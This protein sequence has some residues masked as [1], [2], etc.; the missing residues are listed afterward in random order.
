MHSISRI[1]EIPPRDRL[2]PVAELLVAGALI[3]G[4]NILDVVPTSETPWLVALGWLSLRLRGCSWR[5]LG[6]PRP[7]RWLATAGT[8]QAPAVALQLISELVIEPLTGRADLSEFHSLAGILP[9]SLGMLAVVWTMAAFGEEMAHRGH[10]LA[11]AAAL[12]HYSSSAYA[13]AI[14]VGL[15]FGFG[16][17]YQGLA[18]MIGST[19]SGLLF[20]ALDLKAGR[21]LRLPVLAHGF[22]IGKVTAS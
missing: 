8:A 12:G 11:R 9:A 5:T 10:V 1:S 4:A 20:G 13:I 15:L 16:H 6:F 19:V 14:V 2:W 22:S 3:L 21:S 18:G 17:F 7:A